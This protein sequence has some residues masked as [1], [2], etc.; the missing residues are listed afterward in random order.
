M[1]DIPSLRRQDA[2]TISGADSLGDTCRF[3]NGSGGLQLR[4]SPKGASQVPR[5]RRALA[6]E[7]HPSDDR[8]DHPTTRD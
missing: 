2:P 3:L 8:H 4:L 6:R 1:L 7:P 5:A